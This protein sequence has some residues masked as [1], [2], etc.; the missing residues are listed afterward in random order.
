MMIQ[1]DLELKKL[2]H[3]WSA[4]DLNYFLLQLKEKEN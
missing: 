2:F 3:F 1:F 4:V